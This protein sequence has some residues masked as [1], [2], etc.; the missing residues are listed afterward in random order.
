MLFDC[1]AH[2]PGIASRS[3]DV[4]EELCL[5][6]V[7][8]LV[9]TVVPGYAVASKVQCAG[10]GHIPWDFYTVHGPRDLRHIQAFVSAGDILTTC[11]LPGSN[12]AGKSGRFVNMGTKH[13]VSFLCHPKLEMS[14][15]ESVHC[16]LI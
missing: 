15:S 12:G 9:N 16:P 4:A 6:V 10:I 8:V 14:L 1:G 13:G 5:L 11:S 3:I 2:E 7:V